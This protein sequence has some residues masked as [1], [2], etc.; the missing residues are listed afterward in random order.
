[1]GHTLVELGNGDF[2]R[3]V[4][5]FR[6]V[7]L[8]VIRGQFHLDDVGAKLRGQMGG[9]TGYIDGGFAGL[10]QAAAARIRPDDYDQAVALGFLGDRADLFLFFQAQR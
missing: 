3:F 4:N 6:F 9:I 8:D 5:F 10:A 1:V 2:L 7:L